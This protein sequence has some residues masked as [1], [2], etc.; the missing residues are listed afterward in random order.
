MEIHELKIGFTPY[1]FVM[2]QRVH[3]CNGC[4][5]RKK[6]GY[7]TFGQNGNSSIWSFDRTNQIEPLKVHAEKSNKL[8]VQKNIA[9]HIS[10]PIDCFQC[11]VKIL[12]NS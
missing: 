2:V 8:E 7:S 11:S 1:H 12:R 10:V 6:N 9:F 5:S 4:N 3:V